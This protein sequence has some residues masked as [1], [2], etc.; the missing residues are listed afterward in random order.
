MS[1][2]A[3]RITSLAIVYPTV[4]SGTDQRKHQSS[5]LL[6]FVRGFHR[7]PLN[8]PHKWPVTRKMF[9]FDDVI[10]SMIEKCRNCH[11]EN[12]F[13]FNWLAAIASLFSIQYKKNPLRNHKWGNKLHSLQ[14]KFTKIYQVMERGC[15]DESVS[16]FSPYIGNAHANINYHQW[17]CKK[18]THPWWRH[19]ME[20]FFALLA[21]CAGN[22]PVTGEFPTQRPVTRSFAVSFDLRLNKRLS[23]QSW[24]W[25]FETPTCS[26]WRHRNV[27]NELLQAQVHNDLHE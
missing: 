27:G 20:T 2:V 8:S 12:T 25:W 17:V 11:Y 23:K 26:L 16:C 19:Q 18:H 6:A 9:P 3:S 7:E 15:T 22:S 5:A 1:E 14:Q 24:G 10:M 4:Y 13:D 21:L